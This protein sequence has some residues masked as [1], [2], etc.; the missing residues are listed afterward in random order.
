MTKDDFIARCTVSESGNQPLE[1][2]FQ[3]FL[4]LKPSFLT[5]GSKQRSK[6]A[7]FKTSVKGSLPVC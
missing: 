3:E 4:K 5:G 6:Y 7:A 1:M 2:T